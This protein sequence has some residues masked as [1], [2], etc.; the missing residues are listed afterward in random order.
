[1]ESTK[2]SVECVAGRMGG[3]RLGVMTIDIFL[4]NFSIKVVD[5]KSDRR[6]GVKGLEGILGRWE[7]VQQTCNW[8]HPTV[9][10]EMKL[11]EKLAA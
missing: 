1:M 2:A 8:I 11:Q 6:R 9:K 7:T 4:W 10:Q 5:R 3:E